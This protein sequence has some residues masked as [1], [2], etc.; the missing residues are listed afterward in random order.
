MSGGHVDRCMGKMQGFIDEH[1]RKHLSHVADN[2][3]KE[4]ELLEK[5]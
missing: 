5:L 2:E 1:M 4:S 3:L